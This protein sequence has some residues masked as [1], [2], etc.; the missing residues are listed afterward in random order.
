MGSVRPLMGGGGARE[1]AEQFPGRNEE[2][3]STGPA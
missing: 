2:L 1:E 3:Q